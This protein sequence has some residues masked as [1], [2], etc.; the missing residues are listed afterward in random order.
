MNMKHY[1]GIASDDRRIHQELIAMG[2]TDADAPVNQDR[3]AKAFN[4]LVDLLTWMRW[5]AEI[6]V[7]GCRI[8]APRHV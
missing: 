2:Y 8:G 1:T 5:K 7:N 3:A 6:S 4:Q